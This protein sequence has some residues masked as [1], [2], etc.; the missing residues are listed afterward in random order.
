MAASQQVGRPGPHC[1]VCDHPRRRDINRLLARGTASIRDI[2]GRFG[3]S[4]SAVHRHAET[5]LPEA[6]TEAAAAADSAEYASVLEQTRADMAE[7]RDIFEA[8]RDSGSIELALKAYDRVD[9][10]LERVAKVTGELAPQRV[11][12][13]LDEHHPLI[14]RLAAGLRAACEAFDAAAERGSAV[15]M[16]LGVLGGAGG[17]ADGAIVVRERGEVET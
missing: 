3:L 6:L 14:Q 13:T 5:C 16:V 1:S 9:R 17:E 7:L 4:K 2:S 15:E 8:A 12:V 10:C 11:E